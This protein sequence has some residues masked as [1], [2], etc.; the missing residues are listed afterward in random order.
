MENVEV[1]AQ[2]PAMLVFALGLVA[3]STAIW[4]VQWFLTQDG[5]AHLY[6]AHILLKLLQSDARFGQFYQVQWQPLP[7][8]AGHLSLMALLSFLSPRA[9]DRVMITLTFAGLACAIA[10]LRVRLAGWRGATGAA[11]LAVLL[12][13]NWM[14]LMGFYSFLLGASM[15]T[16]TLG[17]WWARRERFGWQAAL[18]IAALLVAGYF[19]HLVSL[20]VTVISLAVLALTTPGA[21][22]ARRL[23]WT[24]AACA[25]LVPLLWIYRGLMQMGGGQA[26]PDWRYMSSMWSPRAWLTRWSALE[27]LQLS[28]EKLRPFSSI[29]SS[30]HVLLSPTYIIILALVLLLGAM[31]VAWWRSGAARRPLLALTNLGRDAQ[32][33]WWLLALLLF[34]GWLLAPDDFG[35]EHGSLLRQRLLLLALI[36]LVPL[37]R[38]DLPAR[39]A[40]FGVVLVAVA[41]ALQIVWVWD[42]ALMSNRAASEF[43][44]AQAFVGQRQR[45]GT[46]LL[47]KRNPAD[48]TLTQANRGFRPR[49][50][51]HLDGLLGIGNGNILW[52]NYE[53]SFYV[54]PVQY[55]ERAASKRAR[56][57]DQANGTQLPYSFLEGAPGTPPIVQEYLERWTRLLTDNH[58][59]IDLLV[60]WGEMPALEPTLREWYGPEPIFSSTN[61]RIFRHRQTFAQSISASTQP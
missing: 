43:M 13:L 41:V 8:W 11:L 21:H 55:R 2:R 20:G 48:N 15:F 42:Y 49:P 6:N 5:S 58:D 1:H 18:I 56:T 3:V 37:L 44:Q 45:I 9:A 17:A 35:P 47:P 29:E 46:V 52:N 51:F 27:T 60:V 50:I 32:R 30:W 57:F 39:P 33:G 38:F 10:W 16:L 12:A 54:F 34:G 7:N 40:R 19:C 59:E 31:L 36:T 26:R 23:G 22:W 4:G 25:P 61:L 28:G 53:A 14:W 24:A